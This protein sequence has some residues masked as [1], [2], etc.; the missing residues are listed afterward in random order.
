VIVRLEGGVGVA[1]I[2][3]MY[4][5]HGEPHAEISWYWTVADFTSTQ[6]QVMAM[7]Y[8]STWENA[9]AGGGL[10][11]VR[12]TEPNVSLASFVAR[13]SVAKKRGG[14]VAYFEVS[15]LN[16]DILLL[17]RDAVEWADILDDDD[18]DDDAP[19]SEMPM[20]AF[21]RKIA[22]DAGRYKVPSYDNTCAIIV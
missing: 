15:N 8:G 3:S 20:Q 4:M 11:R 19:L 10:L 16:F 5:V 2:L 13:Q 1:Q 7:R 18:D 21:R 22:E 6:K 9:F 14:N 17:E 12:S